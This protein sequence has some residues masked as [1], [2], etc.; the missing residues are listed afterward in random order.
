MTAQA[1]RPPGPAG[2]SAFPVQLLQMPMHRLAW[3]LYRA[4]KA[5]Q[6]VKWT[7]LATAEG[8]GTRVDY[9]G[10][11]GWNETLFRHVGN[12]VTLPDPMEPGAFTWG[13]EYATPQAA[14]DGARGYDI[15][16]T[17][18]PSGEDWSFP[19]KPGEWMDAGPWAPTFS[20]TDGSMRYDI[21]SNW[22]AQ[23]TAFT[24]AVAAE[25]AAWSQ[26]L[27]NWL[28][29][30]QAKDPQ[31]PVAIADIQ[32]QITAADKLTDSITAA[33][34]I[35][36]AGITDAEETDTFRTNW[37]LFETDSYIRWIAAEEVME[38]FSILQMPLNKFRADWPS[39]VKFYLARLW[40]GRGAL[41][42]PVEIGVEFLTA[43]LT[44]A[45]LGALTTAETPILTTTDVPAL[46]TGQLAINLTRPFPVPSF[47][48]PYGYNPSFRTF[49]TQQLSSLD[50]DGVTMLT[51]DQIS[52]IGP[53]AIGLS[54]TDCLVNTGEVIPTYGTG[55]TQSPPSTQPFGA[56]AGVQVGLFRIEDG[57]I[58]GTQDVPGITV[59]E[60]PLFAT[61]D[62]V[63]ALD[64]T[65][66]ITALR[67]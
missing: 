36:L 42:S 48:E 33:A 34:I 25:L 26:R 31:D 15:N 21:E 28:A 61:P 8:L 7:P 23:G 27:N 30:E 62:R 51:T 66:R 18:D 29:A 11:P 35:T 38:A 58:I 50:T 43:G 19:K 12:E 20:G 65:W 6:I 39:W 17:E 1:V 32:R 56:L 10:Q 64:I 40:F 41:H 3:L 5:R 4:E 55:V 46:T 57:V 16:T 54:A 45:A 44:T 53:A 24:S 67:P 14:R 37:A 13:N 47:A 49:F 2:N 9:T 22:P 63:G 52:A 59:Y 60:S